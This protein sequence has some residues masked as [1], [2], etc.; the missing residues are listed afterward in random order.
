MTPPKIFAQLLV[1]FV[2]ENVWD[3]RISDL[4]KKYQPKPPKIQAP[5]RK[6]KIQQIPKD[7][8]HPAAGQYGL[9]AAQSLQPGDHILDY[10]GYVTA[11]Q[12][13]EESQYIAQLA[14][15]VLIDAQRMGSEAR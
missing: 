14:P 5:C 1:Q 12:F 8:T 2:G 6:V 11:E 7:T 10:L 9:F 3:K 4:Q 13:A 15:T